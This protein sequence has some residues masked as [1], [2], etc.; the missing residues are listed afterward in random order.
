[1]L[2]SDRI[3]LNDDRIANLER[4]LVD[5]FYAN[6]GYDSA[7]KEASGRGYA[8]QLAGHNV[9]ALLDA[10]WHQPEFKFEFAPAS[11]V[12]K[13]AAKPRVRVYAVFV[14]DNAEPA[15][16]STE[17]VTGVKAA[18]PATPVAPEIKPAQKR[19]ERTCKLSSATET[20]DGEFLI[21]KKLANDRGRFTPTGVA[22]FFNA[23]DYKTPRGLIW[24][25]MRV[26]TMERDV[27]ARSQR[28]VDA[29]MSKLRR[30]A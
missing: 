11:P 19:S 22:D 21:L 27:M 7:E 9:K 24:S 14:D 29:R 5:A 12:V 3:I 23:I 10:G 1:M 8:R 25:G 16:K 30:Q 26:R 17:N 4:Q 18:T 13:Q 20:A 28:R 2:R 15:I 6:G